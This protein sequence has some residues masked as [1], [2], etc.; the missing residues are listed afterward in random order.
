M[1]ATLTGLLG[2]AATVALTVPQLLWGDKTATGF[3]AAAAALLWPARL[4]LHRH[5]RDK[6][7][8]I[9]SLVLFVLAAFVAYGYLA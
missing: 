4:L 1:G 8:T 2:L 9:V 5:T 3:A 6:P 7:N